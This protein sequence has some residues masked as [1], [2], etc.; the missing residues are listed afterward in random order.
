M[1]SRSH[2]KI[3]FQMSW[4]ED[5]GFKSWLKP[6]KLLSQAICTLCNNALI[7]VDN[8]GVSTL[9]SHAQGKNTEKEK[10]QSPLSCLFFQPSSGKLKQTSNSSTSS[11]SATIG[12]LIILLSVSKAE[13]RLVLMVVSSSFSLRLY[14][15]LNVLSKEIFSFSKIAE[16]F[17]LSK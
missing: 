12:R 1:S 15:N 13:I 3:N 11:S 4:L 14:L 17:K 10:Q 2:G 9:S 7:S 5:N 8:M 16:N 6:G